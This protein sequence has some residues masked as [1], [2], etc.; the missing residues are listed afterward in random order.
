M[1]LTDITNSFLRNSSKEEQA[2]NDLGLGDKI[3]TGGGR[4]I[5]KDGT[6]NI[7]RE[8]NTDLDISIEE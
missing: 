7:I 2:E 6:F 8:G 1:K 3:M 4:L 5:N